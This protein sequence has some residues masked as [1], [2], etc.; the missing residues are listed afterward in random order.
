MVFR[1][2]TIRRQ[3]RRRRPLIRR[4]MPSRRRF[5][6][7][8]RTR[9]E[10]RIHKFKF[11]VEEPIIWELNPTGGTQPWDMSIAELLIPLASI[12]SFFNMMKIKLIIAK[13]EP[14]GNM[15][16][17]PMSATEVV[18]RVRSM[19][20]YSHDGTGTVSVATIDFNTNPTTKAHQPQRVFFRKLYPKVRLACAPFGNTEAGG[21]L[22]K[23]VSAGWI[24]L[25]HNTPAEL[26]GMAF[27]RIITFNDPYSN[28]VATDRY[29]YKVTYTTYVHFKK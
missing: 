11:S 24:D 12:K 15:I 20:D 28:V 25:N 8:Y 10:Q 13:F 5:R 6:T 23:A 1:R 16:T 21:V 9:R 17:A 27:G 14:M 26:G 7:P 3:T 4:R 29:K 18:P 22:S 2:R 19:I